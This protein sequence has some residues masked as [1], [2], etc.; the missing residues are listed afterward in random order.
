MATANTNGSERAGSVKRKEYVLCVSLMGSSKPKRVLLPSERRGP[1]ICGVGVTL[2][3]PCHWWK[4]ARRRFVP[5][6]TLVAL[7]LVKVGASRWSPTI[8]DFHRIRM[9]LFESQRPTGVDDATANGT[10]RH[11]LVAC[12]EMWIRIVAMVHQHLSSS[13]CCFVFY[14]AKIDD[15]EMA[16]RLAIKWRKWKC[17]EERFK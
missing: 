6:A 12:H 3:R 10:R 13:S 16:G 15:A 11:V 2:L 5:F 17:R 7:V 1:I 4:V 14:E 9:Q 8:M